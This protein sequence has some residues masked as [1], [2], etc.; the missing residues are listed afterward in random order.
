M[1]T[2]TSIPN[3]SLEP[4]K[5]IRSIDGLALRDNPI[6]ITEGAAGAPK[7]QNAAIQ[8]G[9]ISASKFQT[10]TGERDWVLARTSVASV[11]A[12]GT[13]AFLRNASGTS[14]SPGGTL[15]GSSLAYGGAPS[16][17][18]YA[19]SGTWRCMGYSV[20]G[21]DPYGTYTSYTVWLRIS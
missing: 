12:V 8:D 6:A 13:Y 17:A 4:G 3:S 10:G 2:Y 15:A 5:P 20:S 7:I 9:A 21:S 19:P 1:T 18:T 11:G 14:V 16:Y